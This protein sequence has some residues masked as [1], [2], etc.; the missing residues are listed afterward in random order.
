VELRCDAKK[1]AELLKPSDDEGVIEVRCS[2]RW[3]GAGPGIIVLHQFS[4]RDGKLM[5]TQ[6]FQQ[7]PMNEGSVGHA[8]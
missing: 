7:P 1:H 4:T 6:K 5:Q 2:S 8:P 3:C